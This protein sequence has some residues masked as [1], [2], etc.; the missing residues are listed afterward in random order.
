MRAKTDLILNG[1]EYNLVTFFMVRSPPRSTQI[2]GATLII[3]APMG[4]FCNESPAPVLANGYTAEDK[5]GNPVADIVAA[6][7][8][9]LT[10]GT[11]PPPTTSEPTQ[12]PTSEPTQAPTSEPTQ[13]P[14]SE[15]TQAPTSEPTQAPSEPV[16]LPKAVT[17]KFGFTSYKLTHYDTPIYTKNTSEAVKD[18]TKA[19]FTRWYQ[20]KTDANEE[21][22]NAKIIWHTGDNGPTIYLRDF[23]FD[24]YNIGTGNWKAK[25]ETNS[26]TG[27][28][29]WT[30]SV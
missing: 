18:T 19:D 16:A 7:Y 3:E 21:N 29:S 11:T 30:T 17:I 23:I 24:E 26:E 20:T 28:T 25:R 27:V 12:A 14:T 13:A 2:N 5:D 8:V 15:P 22:Y 4:A 6:T 10:P 9:K 1:G